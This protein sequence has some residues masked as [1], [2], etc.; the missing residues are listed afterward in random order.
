MSEY[1]LE[2]KKLDVK[3]LAQDAISDEN[4][5][6]ELLSGVKSKDNTIRSNSFQALL[7]VSKDEPEFLYPEWDYFH[8]LLLS[9]NNY[10]KYIAIYILANLTQADDKDKF[11]E[12]FDDYF[13]ILA[14]E[15]VMNASHVA[16]NSPTIIKN[17]PELQ[18]KIIGLLLDIE[19]IHQGKQKELVKAYVIEALMKIYPDAQD[20]DKIREFVKS[21]LESS[22]PKTRDMASCFLDR[23]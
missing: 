18:S 23:C 1:N 21:Q 20:K 14:G 6:K 8:D 16:L 3:N 9:T 19:N 11:S 15:K 2:D 17:K 4:L 7:I 5:F 10:H 12:I 22:S 13:G